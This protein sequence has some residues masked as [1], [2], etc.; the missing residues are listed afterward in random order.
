[1]VQNE[2]NFNYA[3]SYG[4]K[5]QN[6]KYFRLGNAIYSGHYQEVRQRK[7]SHKALELI[8]HPGFKVCTISRL[9]KMKLIDHTIKTFQRM[10]SLEKSHLYLFGEGRE[11]ESLMNLA[12]ELGIEDRVHFPGNVDQ[13]TLASL[14]PR[15]D[16]VLSPSMG[17]AL[18]EV[19]L[20]ER[21][22]VAYNIDCHPEI[23]IDG[24]SGFLVKYLDIDEMSEKGDYML[25][26]PS[27]AARMGM[28]AREVAMD[29][30]DPEKL[31]KEQRQVFLGLLSYPEKQN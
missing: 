6:I 16:L 18:T 21:P 5:R 15:I 27:I 14:L 29:L 30:M 28:A 17:R 9:E 2:D 19:A 8:D 7:T 4:A 12:R 1:M 26:N 31:I 10:K 24:K 22:I 25:Q 11:R 3:A 23:V 20:A 13:E